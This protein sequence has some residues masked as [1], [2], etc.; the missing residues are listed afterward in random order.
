MID[1]DWGEDCCHA[2]V[3]QQQK[4]LH[5]Q[6]EDPVSLWLSAYFCGKVLPL[7]PLCAATTPF[8]AKMRVGLCA[9]PHG[10]VRTYGELAKILNTA[11][12][13]LGRA[14]GVNP[15]PLLIPCHR[16]VKANALGGFHAGKVWKQRLIDGEKAAHGCFNP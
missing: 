13:A 3:L 10:E 4:S 8:Q 15:L 7:P 2:V 16:I 14:L 9:I 12:R 1:Y 6:H 11:P 5:P